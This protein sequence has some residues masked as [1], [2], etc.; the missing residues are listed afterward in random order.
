M[1]VAPHRLTD[2]NALVCHRSRADWVTPGAAFLY[3]IAADELQQKLK[4]VNRA[5]TDIAVV[6]GA[7]D[8]WHRHFPSARQ[9]D[10]TE[11]LALTPGQHDLVIHAMTLHWADDP[12]GQL[13]Q[14]RRALTTDGLLLAVFAGGDTLSELRAALA[15]AEADL[16]GGLSPRI[17]P[18]AEIRA[19]GALL[20]RAG[21]AL[22]V[23]DSVAQA[24]RY[25]DIRHLTRD[26]RAMGETN[27]LDGRMRLP[28]RREL[29]ARADAILRDHF[30]DG[31]GIRAT[32][33]LI[34][35]SG[36]APADTQQQPLRPGSAT[37][38]L[39]EALNVPERPANDPPPGHED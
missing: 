16:S 17:A 2:R 5:F 14:C 28:S 9:V 27:A 38:R 1:S 8:Y 11:T 3:D 31:D 18:M 37:H 7:P 13:I 20:Q 29:F 23:A 6:S 39:A 19:A 24:A 12:V 4:D 26:L 30:P 22:P 32:F 35:L 36:W 34:F 10:D 33:E 21:L 15:T 25:R